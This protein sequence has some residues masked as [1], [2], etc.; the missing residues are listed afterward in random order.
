MAFSLRTRWSRL[1][2]LTAAVACTRLVLHGTPVHSATTAPAK[3][4]EA[5]PDSFPEDQVK[6][7]A[8]TRGPKD[9][10]ESIHLPAGYH[11]EL[12]ASEPDVICPVI[13]AWD[14]N[15]RM[16]VAEMRTYMPDI[17]GNDEKLPISRVSRWESTK[18]DGVYDKHTVFADKLVLPRMILPLD[19]RILIRETDTKDIYAYR[20]T[21]GTGEADEKTL[22]FKGGEQGGNLE[23]Q[24]S[25]LMWNIDNWIY[26][27]ADNTRFH[28]KDGKLETGTCRG[29]GG[30]WGLAVE[31]TGRMIFHEAGG[32]NPGHGFQVPHLYGDI[33]LK[34]EWSP[35]FATVYPLLKFTDVQGGPGRLSPG[36][37]LNH[38][39]GCA[40]GSIYRG[41]ALPKDLYGDYILPEPVGRLIRRAKITNEDGRFVLS[42]AY[43]QK[44][45]IAST[46][47]NFRPVWTATGPD[48][49]LYICD[50]YH[51]IIQESAWTKEGSF[52]RPQILK[53]GLDKHVNAGRIFRLVHD[54]SKPHAPPH[55]LDETPAELVKHLSDPNGWWRDTAQKLLVIKGDKSVVPALKE[56][57]VK[58]D[59]PL[60]RLHAL[61]TLDGL[62]AAD[63]DMVLDKLKDPDPRVREAAVR[64]SEPLISAN[65][66]GVIA[67]LK[68]LATDPSPNVVAQ[69][70]LS[71][72]YVKYAQAG[73][74]VHDA[75]VANASHPFVKEVVEGHNEA[76]A[77]TRSDQDKLKKL[78]KEDPKLYAVFV[79][80]KE[81][82]AQACIACHGLNGEGAPVPQGVGT[83]APPL[84]GSKRLPGDV[85]ILGRIV[86]HGLVGPNNGKI[87]PGDMAGIPWADDDWVSSIVTYARNDWGNKAPIVTPQEVAKIRKETADRNKPFTLNELLGPGA[88]GVKDGSTPKK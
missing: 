45:F 18:G 75:V 80:G 11:L 73:E 23:H 66:A 54:G 77:A 32:E 8:A 62:G 81:R 63:R 82:F 21:K 1:A 56:L 64:V 74:L 16:Y 47:A 34:N 52:L 27:T 59:N 67:A 3:A 6:A 39:T 68:Q 79:K 5:V 70:C 2:I 69:Y 50:M 83:L 61:W 24:P 30:Q 78:Q 87:Y 10:I 20:D 48:G 9:E 76:V 28:Y 36:G 14:G 38:F 72:Q 49:Y 71:L 86:I 29:A 42:N 13:C 22:V 35:D 37:G 19:D 33:R 4:P 55:M 60:A 53:Y 65:D 26:I 15:G 40:G 58:G 57:A 31:D 88:D 46:D 25:G 85:Q 17:N 51:G 43:D 44:E 41:D 7:D 84:K 12:V